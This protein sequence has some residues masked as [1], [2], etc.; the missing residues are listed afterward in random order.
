MARSFIC[1]HCCAKY[2][3]DLPLGTAVSCDHCGNA[4]YVRPFFGDQNS[5]VRMMGGGLF[6]MVAGKKCPNCKVR[7]SARI[8]AVDD[9]QR[10]ISGRWHNCWRSFYFCKKCNATWYYAEASEA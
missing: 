6:E 10:V 4:F 1:T 7:D 2:T 9:G 8:R 5:I 3:G